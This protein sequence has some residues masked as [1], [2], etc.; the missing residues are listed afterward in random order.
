MELRVSR[1]FLFVLRRAPRF[2]VLPKE[3]LDQALTFAAFDQTVAILF[4]DE[5]VYQLLAGQQA[6][7]G[8]AAPSDMLGAL[9]LYDVK[10]VWVEEESLR[11]RG[12]AEQALAIPVQMVARNAVAELLG[13]HDVVVTDA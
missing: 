1:R 10:P 3:T 13:R 7:P 5:G 4:L 8:A 2:G 9:P 11:E 12:L 6:S